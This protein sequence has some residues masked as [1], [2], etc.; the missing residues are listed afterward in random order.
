[1]VED[2]PAKSN[3]SPQRPSQTGPVVPPLA[4]SARARSSMLFDKIGVSL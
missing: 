2:G 3:Q 4:F 1:M